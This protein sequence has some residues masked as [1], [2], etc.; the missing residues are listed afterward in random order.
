MEFRDFDIAS[1][2][3]LYIKGDVIAFEDSFPGITLSSN[4][5]TEIRERV[6]GISTSVDAI[7]ITAEF[8]SSPVGFVIGSLKRSMWFRFFTLN[9]YT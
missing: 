6:K 7:G 8:E 5:I 9:Q 3:E 1:D 4:M 2:L